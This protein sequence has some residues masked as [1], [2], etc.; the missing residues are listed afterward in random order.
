MSVQS[1]A[2]AASRGWRTV[3]QGAVSTVLVAVGAVVVDQ[4]T[5]GEVVDYMTVGVAAA[6]AAGTALAA[7]AQRILE[8]LGKTPTPEE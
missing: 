7:Y 3:L 5:P 6:T 4:V 1:R 8:G 2:D